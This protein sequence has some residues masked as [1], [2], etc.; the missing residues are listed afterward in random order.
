MRKDKII[1]L[2]TGNFLRYRLDLIDY[3]YPN[4]AQEKIIFFVD[5]CSYEPLPEEY[6]NKYSFVFIEDCQKDY[7]VSEK[8]EKL[9]CEPDE[10][11]Y[12]D[13]I[14]TFYS[15]STGNLYPYHITRLIFPYLIKNDIKNFIILDSDYMF[16]DNCDEIDKAF[17]FLKPGEFHFPLFGPKEAKYYNTLYKEHFSE[18]Y[19]NLKFNI[20]EI[21]NW[22]GFA[23]GFHF[24]SL[25]D[26]ELFFNLWNDACELLLSDYNKLISFNE[27]S[28]Q[29]MLSNEWII[30]YITEVFK[31]N[32]NYKVENT[33][34]AF[35]SN[36]S[37]LNI[38]RHVSRPEEKLYYSYDVCSY[39]GYEVFTYENIKTVADF[40]K[41][42]KEALHNFYI[43][44]IPE[45]FELII[46]DS[47]VYFK[48][49]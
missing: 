4:V 13:K 23:K 40:V 31:D 27:T 38:G 41:K 42:N 28:R 49:K 6:K 36:E 7:P 16:I 21:N 35:Y 33:Y 43:Y 11:T 20:K 34:S 45:N 15:T 29:M 30:Q 19:K 47:H 1:M 44:R 25:N 5:K 32:L 9:L 24:R 12:N 26:M 39:P 17:D 18:K 46:T 10:A 3:G 22:D 2:A 8:Y 48:E 37:K 14:K